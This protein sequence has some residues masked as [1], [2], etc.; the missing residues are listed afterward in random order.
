[1]IKLRPHQLAVMQELLHEYH[2]DD[3]SE[4]ITIA[5]GDGR[6][7]RSPVSVQPGACRGFVADDA[8]AIT[9]RSPQTCPC[10]VIYT[11][12]GWNALPFVGVQRQEDPSL[13]SLELRNCSCGNTLSRER[14]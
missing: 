14:P 2:H 6:L 9:E 7:K 11:I 13:P 5:S 1:M 4:T 10:G 8:E 3:S 12:E